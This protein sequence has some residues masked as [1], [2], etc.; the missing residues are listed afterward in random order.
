M[1]KSIALLLVIAAAHGCGSEEGG[2]ADVEEYPIAA[3][4][5]NAGAKWQVDSHTRDSFKR[6]VALVKAGPA[7]ESEGGYRSFGGA[8]HE[9]AQ[10]LIG[11]CRMTGP[12]HDELHVLLEELLPRIAVLREGADPAESRT[13]HEEIRRLCAEYGAH[14]E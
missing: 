6:I 7:E 1:R 8:L 2:R 3:L 14:F 11:G 4:E 9:Q 5:L 10:V 13:V 12:A